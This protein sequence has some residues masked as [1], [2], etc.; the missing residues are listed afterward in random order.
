M[1]GV[2]GTGDTAASFFNHIFL[3][4]SFQHKPADG[5]AGF[6]WLFWAELRPDESVVITCDCCFKVF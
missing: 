1:V 6:L 3:L 2:R 5:H 4:M